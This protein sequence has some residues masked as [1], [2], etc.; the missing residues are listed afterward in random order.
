MSIY[1]LL[2]RNKIPICSLFIILG[3]LL[4]VVSIMG[5]LYSDGKTGLIQIIR[6]IIGN[7]SY[8][9]VLLSVMLL[10]VG[11]FYFIDFTKKLKEFKNLIG[12]PSKSK[13]I[14][15]LDRI[16]EL[17]WRLHPKYEKIVINKKNEH[18]IK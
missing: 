2:H 15:N 6:D 7:W 18:N 10:A 11:L 3:V 16:E 13:F 14:Q 1:E 5:I 8:W 4:L 12:T 9:F 17:A